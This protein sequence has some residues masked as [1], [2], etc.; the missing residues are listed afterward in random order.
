VRGVPVPRPSCTL[1]CRARTRARVRRAPSCSGTA[2]LCVARLCLS[3]VSCSSLHA[4]NAHNADRE[5]SSEATHA[6]VDGA[7]GNR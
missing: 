5:P 7:C 6:H 2:A 1:S 4:G 3:R